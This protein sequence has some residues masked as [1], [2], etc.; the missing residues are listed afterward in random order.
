MRRQWTSD[1]LIEY[2]TISSQDLTAPGNKTGTTRLGFA[3][4]LKYFQREGR[5][6]RGRADVPL[7][8]A[9]FLAGQVNTPAEGWRAYRWDSRAAKYH[10]AQIRALLGIREATAV[11]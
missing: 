2:W 8:V 9:T 6:P 7:A 4:M 11:D 3:V 5:F 1:E 10:R